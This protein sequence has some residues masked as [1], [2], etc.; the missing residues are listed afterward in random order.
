MQFAAVTHGAA[1]RRRTCCWFD[2]FNS[3]RML[4]FAETC[5]KIQADIRQTRQVARSE[6]CLTRAR[7]PGAAAG[8]PPAPW[9]ML[10]HACPIREFWHCRS[11]MHAATYAGA[12]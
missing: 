8:L 4:L 12:M 9:S 6:R 7:E 5:L 11:R 3:E 1:S 10:P 2:A